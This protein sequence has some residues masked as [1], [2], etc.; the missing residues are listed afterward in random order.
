MSAVC[1]MFEVGNQ[2]DPGAVQVMDIFQ[3]QD[4]CIAGCCA[5]NV[6]DNVVNR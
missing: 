5:D 6:F 1:E 4:Q 2:G 3:I